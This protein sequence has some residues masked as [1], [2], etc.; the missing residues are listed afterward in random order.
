MAGEA[1]HPL[2]HCDNVRSAWQHSE[3]LRGS[4][5]GHQHSRDSKE[6][7]CAIKGVAD[8]VD[9][10]VAHEVLAIPDLEGNVHRTFAIEWMPLSDDLKQ[11]LAALE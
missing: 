3:H 7:G 2:S 1:L 6:A 8:V 11:H 9:G 10:A 5:L 4:T